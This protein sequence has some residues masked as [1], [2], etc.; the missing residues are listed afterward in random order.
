M[1]TAGHTS[2]RSKARVDDAVGGVREPPAGGQGA[3]AGLRR[4]TLLNL[5]AELAV[6]N[7]EGEVIAAVLDL[8]E[9]RRV[10]LVG[11]FREEHIREAPTRAR[12]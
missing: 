7:S 2:E 11:Q 10:Q 3:S 4:V 5:V 9:R 12:R 6:R 1:R 8:V